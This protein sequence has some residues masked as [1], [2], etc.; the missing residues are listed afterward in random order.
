M[1]LAAPVAA[2]RDEHDRAPAS[3]PRA[4][5][6]PP[7]A[8]RACE[9]RVHE[10]GVRLDGLLA[11]G[12]AEVGGAQEVDV[13]VEVLTEQTRGGAGGAGRRARRACHR[14]PFPPG[15]RRGGSGGR[16]P[17]TWR[18]VTTWGPILSNTTG[19]CR[20]SP[21]AETPPAT[22]AGYATTLAIRPRRRRS[23]RGGKVARDHRE[24]ARARRDRPAVGQREPARPFASRRSRRS[25][26]RPRARTSIPTAAR[27]ACARCW[28]TGSACP[29]T[30]SWRATGRTR[31]S[32]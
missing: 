2:E 7:R 14:S 28:A 22:M 26:A 9:E 1:E 6:P 17:P 27:P 30:G 29:P 19:T 16:V 13:R 20:E 31:C 3:R 15:S 10:R 12:S 5:R 32:R 18:N 24:G 21:R 4:W 23:L 11:R 25:A 8:G